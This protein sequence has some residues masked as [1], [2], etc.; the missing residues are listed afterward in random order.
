MSLLEEE[1]TIKK[2]INF[3]GSLL[4]SIYLFEVGYNYRSINSP[5]DNSFPTLISFSADLMISYHRLGHMTYIPF[6]CRQTTLHTTK[7]ASQIGLFCKRRR[8]T[9]ENLLFRRLSDSP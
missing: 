6:I 8:P 2:P 9:H 7:I 5:R 1:K 4:E 3:Q